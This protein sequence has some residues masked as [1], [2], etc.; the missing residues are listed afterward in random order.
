M[1]NLLYCGLLFCS[2]GVG[3][4]YYVETLQSIIIILDDFKNEDEEGDE[5]EFCDIA[6]KTSLRW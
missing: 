5:D 3:L 4:Y 2:I 1:L 6:T